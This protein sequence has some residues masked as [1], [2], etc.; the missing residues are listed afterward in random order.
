MPG[1][2]LAGGV[3]QCTLKEPLCLRKQGKE[4]QRELPK[5]DFSLW[6]DEEPGQG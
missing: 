5:V 1:A 6:S 2:S 3:S 4:R